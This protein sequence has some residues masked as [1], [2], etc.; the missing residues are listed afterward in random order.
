[1]LL[2]NILSVSDSPPSS[3]PVAHPPI[4][5]KLIPTF[6]GEPECLFESRKQ[7]DYHNRCSITGLVKPLPGQ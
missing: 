2:V 5:V 1:M 3:S 4:R 7:T 6:S